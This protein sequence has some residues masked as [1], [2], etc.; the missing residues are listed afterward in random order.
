MTLPLRLAASSIRKA[1][2]KSI[3][4]NF[5]LN[6]PHSQKL[7]LKRSTEGQYRFMSSEKK[8]SDFSG[9]S[10]FAQAMRDQQAK[11]SQTKEPK[12]DEDAQEKEPEE[13]TG[14]SGGVGWAFAL[15]L[16]AS[17]IYLGWN[18]L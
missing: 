7:G 11:T 2:F 10:A 8:D 12:Q 16:L 15:G 1:T 5:L 6:L 17:Y 13:K 3:P 4:L 14:K 9:D 18:R